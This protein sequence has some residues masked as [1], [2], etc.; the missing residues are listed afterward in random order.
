[1]ETVRVWP[2]GALTKN[3]SRGWGMY[4]PTLVG[5]SAA[6]FDGAGGAIHPPR[7]VFHRSGAGAKP[8]SY[9]A[10]YSRSSPD[11]STQRYAPAR[12]QE[13]VSVRPS[14]SVRLQS[15]AAARNTTNEQ[16]AR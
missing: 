1:M 6:G 5:G 11:S 14:A 8:G 9:S 7:R 10:L 12:P 15:T 16:P 3:M 4:Q 13:I 2:A